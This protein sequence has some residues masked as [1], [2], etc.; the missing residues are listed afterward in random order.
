MSKWAKI[1][2]GIV[3]IAIIVIAGFLIYR[4]TAYIS[5]KEAKETL[6]KHIQVEENDIHFENV[7][8]EMDN[9]QYEIDFYYNNQEYEAKI[10]A[11]EGKVIYTD[12]RTNEQSD[13]NTNNN[14]TNNENNNQTD[15]TKEITLEE[16]KEIALKHANLKEENLTLIKEQ[17]DTDDGIAIYDIEWR[18][19]T[20]EYDFEISTSGEV[21]QY[22]K[23]K[24]ND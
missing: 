22:D 8:L 1:L 3:V 19:A 14:T 24:I 10:D 23:D 21:L 4:N 7:D 17:E 2:I 9:H 6:A 20:Y 18:D 15:N 13:N 16:A 11:K 12:F 5:Q